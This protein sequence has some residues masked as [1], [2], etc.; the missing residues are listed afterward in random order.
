MITLQEILNSQSALLNGK[1]VKIVRHKDTQM[2]YRDALK[3]RAVALQYQRE[4]NSDIFARCDYIVSFFGLE[5]RRAVLFG[6][7]KVNGHKVINGKYYYDLEEIAEFQ[8]ITGRLIIDWGKNTRIWHQWHPAQTK[9]VLEILPHGYIGSFPGLLS[10]VLQFDELRTLINNPDANHDWRHHLSAVNGIY[11]ILDSLT[12]QQYIGSANGREGIWQRWSDYAANC[13]GGNK[14]LNALIKKDPTYCQNFR[15]SIL[16][17][18]PS[19]ITQT[20]IVAIENLYK[21]KLGSKTHGL[22]SN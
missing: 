5:R 8:D 7:F 20:E 10:V 16:Q 22:N 9:E 2:Q 11:L 21:Q 3:E 17:T 4:Q 6:V 13:T 15:F 12:G 19:N 18:L 14:E 1:R